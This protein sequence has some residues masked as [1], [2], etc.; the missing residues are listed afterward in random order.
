[1]TGESGGSV[2]LL[3]GGLMQMPAIAA[4]WDWNAILQT[5]TIA[6]P[7]GMWLNIFTTSIFAI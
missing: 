6:V 7:A 1:M 4:A 3:G 5:G 2:F